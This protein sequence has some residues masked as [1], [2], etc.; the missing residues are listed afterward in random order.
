M[1][2][3]HDTSSDELVTVE[4]VVSSLREAGISEEATAQCISN[5]LQQSRK[6]Q[7]LLQQE[8]GQQQLN[9][10][11]L[12]NSALLT[13][14]GFTS[15][16][17][18]PG[19]HQDA[20]DTYDIQ[21]KNF[22]NTF[23]THFMSVPQGLNYPV[24]EQPR[25]APDHGS[26][27]RWRQPSEA[28]DRY[29]HGSARENASKSLTLTCPRS[30]VGRVIGKS[31]ETVNALQRYTGTSIQI[32]QSTD[33]TKM[34]IYGNDEELHMAVS[35]VSDIIQGRFKGF[36]MLRQMA[37]RE[38]LAG[39]AEPHGRSFVDHRKHRKSN[40]K[41]I[42]GYGLMPPSTSPLVSKLVDN[43]VGPQNTGMRPVALGLEQ[44]AETHAG[45]QQ[46]NQ[47]TGAAQTQGVS[48][49]NILPLDTGWEKEELFKNFMIASAEHHER[50]GK[51]GHR[52]QQQQQQEQQEQEQQEQKQEQE[53]QEQ[54][55]QQ[56]Q[57]Q[58]QQEQQQ[59]EQKQQQK[60]EQQK[61][62]QQKQQKQQKQQQQKQQ[63]Q[64]QQQQKHQQQHQE[65]QDHLH[66]GW[67]SSQQQLLDP[68]LE[69]QERL[70]HILSQIANRGDMRSFQ[71]QPNTSSGRN[72]SQNR[73]S[74]LDSKPFHFPDE[75]YRKPPK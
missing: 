56:Q 46:H 10:Q 40:P 38:Q 53:Q 19:S 57:E 73:S 55:K 45:M 31:G 24:E 26:G 18:H 48:S 16:R 1:Q 32:D 22:S 68:H 6:E 58:Q 27:T 2:S 54:Q 29:G 70:L 23:S 62:E 42:Q 41:Y 7:R 66:A 25:P 20:R 33:P 11:D 64:Q 15:S 71:E 9:E 51:Q 63:Q 52:E 3:T 5:L 17:G 8:Q 59:Q 13:R 61:Q 35:M 14:G 39:V 21:K 69:D 72:T 12:S 34:T 75:F 36:A 44:L 50:R 47:A 30:M 67:Q 65:H 43:S 74:P 49:R 28:K 60:Q 37:T 4:Q